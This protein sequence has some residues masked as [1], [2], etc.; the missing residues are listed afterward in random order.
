MG[1]ERDSTQ[2]DMERETQEGGCDVGG[3]GNLLSMT[4]VMYV[5]GKQ[6]HSLRTL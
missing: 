3:K 2:G 5:Q 6:T 1:Q 4:A